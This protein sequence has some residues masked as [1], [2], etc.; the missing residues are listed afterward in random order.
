MNRFDELQTFVRVV[1]TGNISRAAESMHIAKSAVS[2][3]LGDLEQR[4]GV[5]LFQRTTRRLHLTSSGRSFY[6]RAVRILSDLEEA[7][8]A[9]S[10]QHG[11]LC[12]MLRVAVPLSFGLSHLGPAITDFMQAHP[13]IQFDLDFNDR[14]ID[15]IQEGIDVAIRIAKLHDSSYIA[16]RI[17]SIRSVVCASADYLDRFGMPSN[18]Q[19]L[20]HH[21]CLVYSN[22]ADRDI[23]RYQAPDGRAGRVKLPVFLKSN[24]GD[25]L[26]DA[27]V[28]GQ[29]VILEPTFIV[30]SAIEQGKLVPLFPDYH[31]FTINAYAVYPQ[32]RHLSQRVRV[33]VDFLAQRF[34]GTPYWDRWL[35]KP[36]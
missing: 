10:Q 18:P 1:E 33:F 2:R 26:R 15:L 29:G 12:G 28:A 11:T 8:L 7:E 31:W 13:Q 34:S 35:D 3:R 20:Q 30:Y 32:T 23:W 6:E 9:V 16:R 5:Q 36:V 24:N 27:A 22:L 14:Q 4:L 19:H 25:Y 21:S 17:C